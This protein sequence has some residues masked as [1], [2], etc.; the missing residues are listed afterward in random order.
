MI[1][2]NLSAWI[3]DSH[4]TQLD[5]Y[6]QRDVDDETVEYVTSAATMEPDL[7]TPGFVHRCWIPSDEGANFKIIW[8]P[9]RNF[10]PGLGLR[11]SI[12]LDGRVVSSSCLSASAIARGVPGKK[13]GMTVASG[14]R[15]P[16]VFSRQKLTDQD[17]LASPDGTGM[18]NLG[19]IRVTLAWVRITKK[20]RPKR[21]F[22][23]GEPGLLHER[24]AKKGHCTTAALGDP[25]LTHP[26]GG[27]NRVKV[28]A[29]LPQIVFLFKYGP[30]EWLKAKE[31]IPSEHPQPN[32]DLKHNG[33][34]P[35]PERQGKKFKPEP[36][37]VP[38]ALASKSCVGTFDPSEVIDIDD[39]MS[40]PDPDFVVLN[41][42]EPSKA[43]I[44]L[45]D[46][47]E[48]IKSE[49]TLA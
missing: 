30:R 34:E 22:D 20:V 44:K 21:F 17:E 35:K 27:T 37:P 8:Q 42:L 46:K 5:E 3:T 10:E 49:V 25:I 47:T 41:D 13:D 33:T 18:T 23:P 4:G 48:R 29:G 36:S 28:D 19:T 11:C 14:L 43:P 26:R 16:F 45:E 6:Q 39:L 24:A 1:H 9:T 7:L 32:I 38:T 31:I 40:D 12:R 15:R 2:K